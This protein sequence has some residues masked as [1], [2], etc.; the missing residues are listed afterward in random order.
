[1]S[2]EVTF[3]Y[4]ICTASLSVSFSMVYVAPSD[5]MYVG[6]ISLS[7][8]TDFRFSETMARSRSILVYVMRSSCATT[9]FS[10]SHST[11]AYSSLMQLVVENAATIPQRRKKV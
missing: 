8:F 5:T 2:S 9:M 11:L 10:M 4:S 3:T 7:K 6:F 1:M